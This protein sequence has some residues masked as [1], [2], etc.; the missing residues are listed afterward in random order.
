MTGGIAEIQA[1]VAA[2]ETRLLSFSG[3]GAP[4]DRTSSSTS[5]TSLSADA[6]LSPTDFAAAL[7]D[8]TGVSGST[9]STTG[10]AVVADAKKY[11]G[12]PYV[13]GGTDPATGLDCSGLVQRVYKD[14][15][16]TLPR[17]SQDQAKVGTP[18]ASLAL[19]K[20]GD[21]LVFHSDAS[22]IAI[23]AG[24]GQMVEAPRPGLSVRLTNVNETPT[25]IRRVIA[26]PSVTTSSSSAASR[27]QTLFDSATAK[28]GLPASLLSAVA[29][30]ESGY[31]ANARSNAGAVGLMQLMPSTAAGLGV[32]ATNPAQAVDGAARI[33]SSNLKKF[34]TIPLALAAY[35]AGAGAVTKYG[36]VPPYAETQSYV[37]K[38]Q[39]LMQEMS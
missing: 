32:D 1:R 22:H 33:L 3:R 36:G 14:L 11:L 17:V 24:N 21:L 29:S 15:G 8:A 39:A 19:A 9:R 34:G 18:V 13:W 16:I 27:Y 12:V 28:Y 38:V 25:A 20:P 26:P 4:I 2:I 10:D 30:I 5:G 7:K 35:N 31:N 37:R 6:S 23:Y